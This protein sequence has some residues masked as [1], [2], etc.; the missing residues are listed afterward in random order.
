MTTPTPAATPPAAAKTTPAPAPASGTLT[1]AL[2]AAVTAIAV[3][4]TGR[5]PEDQ[6]GALAALG[7]TA[8]QSVAI[9]GTPAT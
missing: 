4:I 6:A 7:L 2:S 3:H 9:T 5:G 8:E 1:S